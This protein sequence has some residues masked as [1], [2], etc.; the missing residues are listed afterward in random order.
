MYLNDSKSFFQIILINPIKKQNEL[1]YKKKLKNSWK[2]RM[3]Y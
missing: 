1:K 3:F 2:D